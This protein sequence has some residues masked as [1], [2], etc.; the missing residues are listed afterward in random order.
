M[1]RDMDLIAATVWGPEAGAEIASTWQAYEDNQA[2]LRAVEESSGR[3]VAAMERIG[4]SVASSG[5]AIVDA[6]SDEMS[7]TRDLLAA[8]FAEL[9][10]Q[11]AMMNRHLEGILE[12]LLNPR[13]TEA[14][15]LVRRG[16]IAL[17]RGLETG[18][19][20]WITP[21][22]ADLQEALAIDPYSYLS[23]WHL[24]LAAF[25][26]SGDPEAALEHF[27]N[28]GRLS[29]TD[30]SELASL[31]FSWVGRLHAGR[32]DHR[33][34]EESAR[35]ALRAN[36]NNAP[37]K[38]ELARSIAAQRGVDTE[39][40]DLVFGAVESEVRWTLEVARFRASLNTYARRE[41]RD[42]LGTHY[43]SV[44]ESVP[45]PEVQL[46][47]FGEHPGEDEEMMIYYSYL[48][49]Q[50]LVNDARIS[51][52]LNKVFQV[53]FSTSQSRLA[54]ID[55]TFTVAAEADAIYKEVHGEPYFPLITDSADRVVIDEAQS[56]V[57]NFE[58]KRASPTLGLL[59]RFGERAN[60]GVLILN[61]HLAGNHSW[62]H[63]NIANNTKPWQGGLR[64][65][66]QKVEDKAA[67]ILSRW[68][69]SSPL[70]QRQTWASFSE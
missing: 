36:P 40:R 12:A 3:S 50:Q 69:A 24:G 41:Y 64:R 65:R 31:A 29:E 9:S 45:N 20:A 52:F 60:A 38:Y 14:N 7:Q 51:Q 33:L 4:A 10:F 30:N 62:V 15:E 32:L 58:T 39:V 67:A 48:S 23:H 25:N 44:R 2:L 26:W 17:S 43:D 53:S 42:Q 66:G 28:A 46:G 47:L 19:D 8:G 1:V 63:A 59:L 22:I 18:D 27:S 56:L 49:D 70:L 55:E 16:S 21:G 13:A 68:S 6:V 61:N 5:M 57:S 35:R 54:A 37:A 11:T 34:A